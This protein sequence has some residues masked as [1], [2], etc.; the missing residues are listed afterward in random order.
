MPDYDTMRV[1]DLIHEAFYALQEKDWVNR[2]PNPVIMSALRRAVIREAT[3]GEVKVVFSEHYDEIARPEDPERI[4]TMSESIIS[5]AWVPEGEYVLCKK[6][7]GTTVRIE[8]KEG[9]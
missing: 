9:K 8:A 4:V 2:E 3:V 5:K 7:G 1:E 6:E